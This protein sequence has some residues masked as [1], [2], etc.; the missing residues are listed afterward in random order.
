MAQKKTPKKTSSAENKKKGAADKKITRVEVIRAMIAFCGKNSNEQKREEFHSLFSR[1]LSQQISLHK[2]ADNYN[3]LVLYDNST[4]IKSD[5]D[6]IYKAI[7]NFDTGKPLML[8]LLSRGGEP[9]SAYL[10]GKLC[11]EF[12]GEK[13]VTVIPRYAKSA[14]TLL[15]CASDEIHMGS[16]SELGPIDPQ[17]RSHVTEKMVPTLGLKN[18]IEHI[19]TLVR[20]YPDSATMFAQFLHLSVEPVQVGYYERVAESAAQY[21]ERLLKPREKLL[22]NSASDTASHLV[23]EYKDHGFVI[24]KGEAL[25]I[26]GNNIIKSSTSEY[27]LGDS[28]Y[29]ILSDLEDFALYALNHRF[30]FIGNTSSRPILQSIPELSE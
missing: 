2:V 3:V 21:A 9:G 8:I 13:F 12:S 27:E 29:E 23:Y 22:P 6:K 24:D 25:E 11:S 16:M 14:A 15:A 4:L 19:A 30:Y 1:Y 18:S 20:K 5:S 7:E 28:V 10:I 26:F 17:I